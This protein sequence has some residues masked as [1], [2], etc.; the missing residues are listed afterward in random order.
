MVERKGKDYIVGKYLAPEHVGTEDGEEGKMA[1][2]EEGL[3]LACA[4]TGK[5]RDRDQGGIENRTD[6]CTPPCVK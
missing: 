5:L 1:K 2:K 4:Q 6:L 3:F